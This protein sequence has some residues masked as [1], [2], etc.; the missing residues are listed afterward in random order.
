MV[1]DSHSKLDELKSEA[2]NGTYG[3]VEI[4]KSVGLFVT[5]ILRLTLNIIQTLTLTLTVTLT[6]NPNPKP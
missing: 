2:N 3:T 5:D 4:F 6:P 1:L